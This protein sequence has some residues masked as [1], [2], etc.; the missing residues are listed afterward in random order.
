MSYYDKNSP[1]QLNTLPQTAHLNF[2]LFTHSADFILYLQF[3]NENMYDGILAKDS[4][5]PRLSVSLDISVDFDITIL[6]SGS[7]RLAVLQDWRFLLRAQFGT[8]LWTENSETTFLCNCKHYK[9]LAMTEMTKW[10]KLF[11]IFLQS[12]KFRCNVLPVLP[13][14]RLRVRQARQVLDD[15]DTVVLQLQP[16][17]GLPP[18]R[19]LPPRPRLLP[20]CAVIGQH[21]RRRRH[22][23][24]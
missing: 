23:G 24:L 19:L 20:R 13:L 4:A 9:L 10:A 8:L 18:P 15:V 11:S 17:L 12:L 6:S 1:L 16:E 7:A 5:L 3:E 14:L 21:R 22:T 2:S